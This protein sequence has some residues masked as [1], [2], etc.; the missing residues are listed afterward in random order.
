MANVPEEIPEE[1]EYQRNLETTVSELI[2][3]LKGCPISLKPISKGERST[4]IPYHWILGH[5]QRVHKRDV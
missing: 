4:R 5:Q 1:A 2:Q 3:V